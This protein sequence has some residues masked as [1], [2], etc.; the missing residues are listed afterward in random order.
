MPRAKRRPLA[1]RFWEKVAMRGEGECWPWLRSQSSAG[2]GTFSLSHDV[3]VNAHVV[4]YF[5]G[6]G[7]WPQQ[8]VDHTCFN[9]LCQ[10]PWHLEDVSLSDNVK[11]QPWKATCRKGHQWKYVRL[12]K[13]GTVRQRACGQCTKP[14]PSWV[15]I[16]DPGAAR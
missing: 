1:E 15:L 2:Y 11:R 6:H 14:R 9:R 13:D 16:G 8:T 3:S 12:R 4:A 10:N 5:L 7:T